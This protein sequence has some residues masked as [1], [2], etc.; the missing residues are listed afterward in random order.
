[1]T[2][3]W[4]YYK[5]TLRVVI[6]RVV[7]G[8]KYG[9]TPPALPRTLPLPSQGYFI[10]TRENNLDRIAC[11]RVEKFGKFRPP[12]PQIFFDDDETALPYQEEGWGGVYLI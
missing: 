10:V 12:A 6:R 5:D 4:F 7:M 1:M 8:H 11:R 2:F 9:N 3:F